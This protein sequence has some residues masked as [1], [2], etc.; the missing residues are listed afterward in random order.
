MFQRS[1]A[2]IDTIESG[3]GVHPKR[4][5]SVPSSPAQR[6]DPYEET[7]PWK[8]LGPANVEEEFLCP[9]N[10]IECPVVKRQEIDKPD[11]EKS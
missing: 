3:T 5:E 7:L 2:S 8:D 10:D 6:T 9:P 11:R 1:K 4:F